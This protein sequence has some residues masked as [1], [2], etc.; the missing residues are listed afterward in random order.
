M[1]ELLA[2][3][4]SSTAA[5]AVIVAVFATRRVAEGATVAFTV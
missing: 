1:A 4:G 3:F 5:G 2:G